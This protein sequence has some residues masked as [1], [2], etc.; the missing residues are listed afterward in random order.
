[1][2]ELI[3]LLLS[4]CV[5]PIVITKISK[6]NQLIADTPYILAWKWMSGYQDMY[7]NRLQTDGQTHRCNVHTGRHREHD[8]M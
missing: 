5:Q 6:K 1:V 4:V 7:T 8:V 3:Y 2:A